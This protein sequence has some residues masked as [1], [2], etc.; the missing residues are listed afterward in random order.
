MCGRI[1]C[2]SL[3]F[4]IIQVDDLAAVLEFPLEGDIGENP[5]ETSISHGVIVFQE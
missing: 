4:P 5:F 2:T 1:V 3:P